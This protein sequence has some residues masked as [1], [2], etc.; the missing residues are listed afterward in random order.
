MISDTF[1][2]KSKNQNQNKNKNQNQEIK[3][4]VIRKQFQ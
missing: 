1:E 3:N 4:K 2:L